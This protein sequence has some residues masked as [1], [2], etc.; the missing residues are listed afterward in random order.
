MIDV[1][2][3]HLVRNRYVLVADAAVIAIAAWCAFALRFGWLFMQG[4][5][6]FPLFLGAAVV[7]KLSIFYSLGLYKRYWRY[8]SFWD[9]MAVVVA[10]TIG[11]LLLDAGMVAL[12]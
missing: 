9:L 10:N 6:E 4:R 12:R 7:A 2:R 3:V 8:A 1:S 11:A 5:T